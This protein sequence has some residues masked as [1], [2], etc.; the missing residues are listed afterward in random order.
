MMVGESERMKSFDL[1]RKSDC[2]IV[3]H[4]G[5]SIDGGSVRSSDLLSVDARV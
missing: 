1:V 3:S 4:V 5:D 2:V